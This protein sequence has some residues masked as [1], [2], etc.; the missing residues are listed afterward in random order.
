MWKTRSYQQVFAAF[1]RGRLPVEKLWIFPAEIPAAGK[2][3]PGNRQPQA[4]GLWE[5]TDGKVLP[6]PDNVVK[7]LSRTESVAKSL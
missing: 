7:A 1:A 6:F 4:L 3:I 5:K 2:W